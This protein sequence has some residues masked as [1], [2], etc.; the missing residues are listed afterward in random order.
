MGEGGRHAQKTLWTT[1]AR[2]T[3]R[4][5]TVKITPKRTVSSR[6]D[7]TG[8]G[9]VTTTVCVG[10]NASQRVMSVRKGGVRE[11]TNTLGNAER[12]AVPGFVVSRCAC[13]CDEW[14]VQSL[15]DGIEKTHRARDDNNKKKK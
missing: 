9:T 6:S 13:V 10:S 8:R 1:G 15:V 4:P 7:T 2:D 3:R 14:E 11:T 12:A 5:N